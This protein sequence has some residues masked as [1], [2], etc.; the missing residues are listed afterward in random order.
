[1]R[2]KAAA[3]GRDSSS[4]WSHQC[5]TRMGCGTTTPAGTSINTASG[6]NASL[7]RTRASPP[8]W[9]CPTIRSA[10][11]MSAVPP[12]PKAGCSPSLSKSP[13]CPLCTSTW[14]DNEPSAETAEARPA[15]APAVSSGVVGGRESV[16][17]ELVDGR[18]APHLLTLGRQRRRGECRVAGHPPLAQPLRPG[19]G[20]GILGAKRLQGQ[21]LSNGGG[22]HRQQHGTFKALVAGSLARR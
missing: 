9:T 2:G 3:L 5:M 8:T 22:R 15:A 20:R 7:R 14:P 16:E 18:I 19:Q 12:N 10:S 4:S 6:K 17:I 21:T 13:G 11:A 1:M